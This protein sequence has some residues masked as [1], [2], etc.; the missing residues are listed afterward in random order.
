MFTA[1]NKHL[2]T[3]TAISGP[4]R[5]RYLT[6]AILFAFV[7]ASAIPLST[8]QKLSKSIAVARGTLTWAVP[9]PEPA[10]I[11]IIPSSVH[12]DMGTPAWDSL[13]PSGGHT[14]HLDQPDGS[15]ST[16]TVAIFHQLRCVGILQ[17]AYFDE[18]SHRTNPLVQHCL[19]YLRETFA[20]HMDMRFESQGS[21]YTHNGF[22]SLCQD[23]EGIFEEAER[24]QRSYEKRLSSR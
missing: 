21:S 8:W 11:R 18:G 17:Q 24:N 22:E 20:C 10:T 4:T 6:I 7:L 14:I 2:S 5:I 13:L 15:V 23:W 19:N 1:A 3:H 9:P 12:F 16:H